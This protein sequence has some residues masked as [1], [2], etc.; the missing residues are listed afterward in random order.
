MTVLNIS[1]ATTGLTEAGI[2]INDPNA[3]YRVTVHAD[4]LH[5]VPVIANL[6]L[7]LKEH[8]LPPSRAE[9][10]G[11]ITALPMR[12]IMRAAIALQF[13]SDHANEAYYRSLV[14]SGADRD[15]AILTVASWAKQID[16]P[17]GASGAIAEFW[18]VSQRT[19]FRWL[20]R[21]RASVPAP[22]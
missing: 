16:R 14:A 1:H 3:P 8:E 4:R 10:I 22:A 2:V 21:A 17:G 6:T 7:D 9:Q 11:F 18:G 12:D 20:A 19:A 13:G 5:N 15:H